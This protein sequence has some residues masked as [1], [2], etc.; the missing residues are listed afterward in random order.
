MFL[1]LGIVCVCVYILRPAEHV[2][3]TRVLGS[4]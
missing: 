2:L 3:S 1:C 4:P